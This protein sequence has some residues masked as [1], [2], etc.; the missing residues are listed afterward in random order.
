MNRVTNFFRALFNTAMHGLFWGWN[1]IFLI[2][3]LTFIAPHVFI[4]LVISS[5]EGSVPFDFVLIPTFL[6]VL[7]I[8]SL[9]LPL[10]HHKKSKN[11]QTLSRALFRYFYAIEVPLAFLLIYRL[12]F[13]RLMTPATWVLFI[14]CIISIAL[15]SISYFNLKKK[16][17]LSLFSLWTLSLSTTTYLS[18]LLLI[19]AI[20]AAINTLR[21][22]VSPEFWNSLY[23]PYT[24][25]FII[26]GFLFF[27]FS[28]GVF[29]ISPIAMIYYNISGWM[30]QLKETASVKSQKQII[31]VS[32]GTILF[33][34]LLFIPLLKQP[35]QDIF[36]TLDKESYTLD[37]KRKIYKKETYYRDKLAQI[38]LSNYRYL[39]TKGGNNHINLMYADILPEKGAEAMQNFFNALAS[40]FLYD[41]D[42]FQEDVNRAERVYETLFDEPLQKAEKKKIKAA[43]QV[44]WEREAVDA[45]LL[46]IDEKKVLLA[47]QDITV[48]EHAPYRKTVE[49]YEKYVNQTFEPQEVFYYFYLPEYAVITGLWLGDTDEREK[50]HVGVISPRGAAQEVYK[51]QVRRRVDPALLEKVGPSQY[52]LRVFP[53]PA[54]PDFWE[55]SARSSRRG[56]GSGFRNGDMESRGE[57]HLWMT[58]ETLCNKDG[59][60]PL[61]TLIQKRNIYWDK[62]SHRTF[63]KEFGH[64]NSEQW[65]PTSKGNVHTFTASSLHY[66]DTTV[67]EISLDTSTREVTPLDGKIAILI[68]VSR[69]M[70]RYE[71]D[72]QSTLTTLEKVTKSSLTLYAGGTTIEPIK[73]AEELFFFGSNS[74]LS[75]LQQFKAQVTGQDFDQLI[76]L[77]D[78]GGYELA[79]DSTNIV[80]FNHP[81]H[82]IHMAGDIP[83]AYPDNLLETVNKNRGLIARSAKEFLQKC[84][85]R[86]RRESDPEFLFSAFPYSFREVSDILSSNVKKSAIAQK[87][88]LEAFASQ[89]DMTTLENLDSIHALAKKHSLVTKYSSMIV[90]VNETQ[91]EQ[92]AL[93]EGQNDRFNREIE[94]GKEEL[95]TPMD[96]MNVSGTPEPEEWMLIFIVLTLGG[97]AIISKRKISQRGV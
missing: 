62:E 64:E 86:Q 95:S 18:L 32:S 71:K 34:L 94:S 37:E 36:K 52:R 31:L 21:F 84:S 78:D 92:L 55:R 4:P 44:T 42:S 75:L 80:T 70:K 96:M 40:P 33:L 11:S 76:L 67:L 89:E 14:A 8:I 6:I 17:T 72:L 97:Y 46:N 49:I 91:K 79:Q 69:S 53:I 63:P 24:F 56:R 73:G 74:N 54:N 23:D 3:V 43:L 88:R 61:P 39:S 68:D 10:R 57:L 9:Y 47:K 41:G 65:L 13:I 20:P 45:G 25:L 58:Y 27:Y 66:S 35:Q 19:Y 93:A 5:I 28:A 81:V 15:Q 12:F 87:V 38:Y 59:S 90:L 51:E 16:P 48:E 50:R 1:L 22:F 7:A 85:D 82:I 77:T 30:R 60:T 26:V 29:I 2:F 83:N